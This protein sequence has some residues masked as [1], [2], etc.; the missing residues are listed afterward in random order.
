MRLDIQYSARAIIACAFVSIT[1]C[2]SGG[3]APSSTTSSVAAVQAGSPPPAAPAR[4]VGLIGEYGPDDDVHR[5]VERDGRLV[6][7]TLREEAPIVVERSDSD[8]GVLRPS[9]DT[10]RVLFTRSADGRATQMR[11][12]GATL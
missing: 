12:G 8:L 2:A 7:R 3:Y 10:A 4:W 5:V 1:A 6:I 11:T 9:H